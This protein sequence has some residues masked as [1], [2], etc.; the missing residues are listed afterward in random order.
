MQSDAATVDMYLDELPPDRAQLVAEVRALVLEALPEGYEE[1]MAFGMITWSVPLTVY[2]DTYNKQ[3][4]VYAALAS[5]KNYVS[6]Y[7]MCAY[8]GAGIGEDEIRARWAGGKPLNMGKSCVRFKA[9]GDLDQPLLREV[10]GQ[11]SVDD[12][13]AIAKAAQRR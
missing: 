4:L 3:P 11:H 13:V 9:I 8:M 12:F 7:L 1:A 6:L 10:I 2:P 5:Q